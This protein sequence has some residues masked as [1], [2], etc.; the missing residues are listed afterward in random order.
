[1]LLADKETSFILKVKI[2]RTAHMF[3]VLCQDC[4]E[5]C[6]FFEIFEITKTIIMG[7]EATRGWIM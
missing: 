2:K 5:N 6:R 4:C 7:K 3:V 1:V